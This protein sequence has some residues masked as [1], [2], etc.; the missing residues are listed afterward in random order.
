M[1]KF[2]K[3][4]LPVFAVLLMLVLIPT[5]FAEDIDDAGVVGV[6]DQSAVDSVSQPTDDIA[7][8]SVKQSAAIDDEKMSVKKK[9]GEGYIDVAVTIMLVA[10]V[11]VFAVNMVSLVALNQNVKTV[12]DQLVDYAAQQGAKEFVACC[13]RENEVSQKLLLR[14]GF[15]YTHSEEVFHPRDQIPYIL[16][17]YRKCL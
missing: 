12:A 4:L 11:L 8:V 2:N 5:A 16:D 3:H 13:R 1:F 17:H 9:K 6:N 15:T 7:V 14:C 10:L